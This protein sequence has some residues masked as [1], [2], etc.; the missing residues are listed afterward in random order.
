MWSAILGEEAGEVA[1]AALHDEFG[2]KAAGTVRAE[3]V[4]L[5]AVGL[6]WIACIDRRKARDLSAVVSMVPITAPE[7]A[8]WILASD[9]LPDVCNDFED[10]E[11][12]SFQASDE[13]LIRYAHPAGR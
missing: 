7:L 6:A 9:R 5:A 8:P 12:Q 1:Q 10:E 13:V 2:G 4:Q 3:L 11:G